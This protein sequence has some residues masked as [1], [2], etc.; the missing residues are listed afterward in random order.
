MLNRKQFFEWLND[1]S[2]QPQ[3]GEAGYYEKA[4]RA[5]ENRI[6]Q[7][8][9]IDEELYWYFLEIL[10]PIY[11]PKGFYMREMSIE[12]ITT[13]F[14]CEDGRYFCQYARLPERKAA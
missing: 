7:K 2:L 13:L 4:V 12:N 6:G 11:A 14:T 8:V 3:H 1:K 9:E 5:Y 10:P